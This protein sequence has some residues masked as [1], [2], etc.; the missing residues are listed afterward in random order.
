[1]QGSDFASSV[2]QW[3]ESRNLI[4]GSNPAAQFKKLMEEST[5]LYDGIRTENLHEIR[6]GIGDCE[7]VLRIIET[8]LGLQ[9]RE[10]RN[11]ELPPVGS[12][13]GDSYA[14]YHAAIGRIIGRIRQEVAARIVGEAIV[15]ARLGL[16]LIAYDY[17]LT[18]S[19]CRAF[20]WNEIKDRKGMMRN[21]V[22]VKESD[23]VTAG[24]FGPE[25][26]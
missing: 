19:E 20:A 10:P 22:F 14:Q 15:D 4:E 6:D 12:A 1:M 24:T 9:F 16:L 11:I 3:G 7:V 13:K 17:E 8:Q 21:G 26:D 25:T 2:S 23:F 5:E 18:I